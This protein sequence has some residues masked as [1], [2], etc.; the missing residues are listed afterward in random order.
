MA[1]TRKGLTERW[2]ADLENLTTKIRAETL[3]EV[4]AV[5][6]EEVQSLGER[7]LPDAE[8]Y[9]LF[10]HDDWVRYAW[11]GKRDMLR[12]IGSILDRLATEGE[13]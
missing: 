13:G 1:D 2:Y 10:F 9:E 12:R 8:A 7:P 5:L 6:D 4:R 11:A 3:A